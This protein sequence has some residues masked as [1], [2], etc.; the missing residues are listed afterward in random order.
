MKYGH[1]LFEYP[2]HIV[3]CPLP[4]TWATHFAAVLLLYLYF[5][6]SAEL[7]MPIGAGV[8]KRLPKSSHHNSTHHT[9]P[10]SLMAF[11]IHS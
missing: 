5:P 6:I 2:E 7:T 10:F 1:I 3:I 8:K 11:V 4:L 9:S